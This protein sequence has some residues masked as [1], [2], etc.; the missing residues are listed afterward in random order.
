[1]DDSSQSPAGRVRRAG[2]TGGR[3]V[4]A[5]ALLVVGLVGG[6]PRANAWGD[7]GH[8]I[9][10]LV[11]GYLLEPAVRARVQALLAA[12]TS[13]LTRDTGIGSEATW[14]DHYRDS[15]RHTT[16][17]RY[18]GTRNWHFVDLELERAD[19][20]AAC[21]QHPGLP[22]GIAASM[23]PAEACII[24]KINEFRAEL[25]SPGT[26]PEE[27]LRALQFLLHL[28]GDLHQPLHACDDH[29]QGGNALQVVDPENRGGNLH[30]YWDSVFVA[31][32]GRDPSTV[33]AALLAGLDAE[34]RARLA[35]GDPEDWALESYALAHD[36]VYG[37]LGPAQPDGRY[38]LSAA[39]VEAATGVTREQ[40]L[41]AGIR[42]ANLLNAALR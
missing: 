16:R 10:A 30:H 7:E 5:L 38:A 41:R 15:D 28:V 22:P 6:L 24:D 25:A 33:A 35:G 13:G 29:D 42:L 23:G 17:Q 19:L 18:D 26:A 39:Y 40:L 8:E 27:R 1:M 11:A 36:Q 3:P 12:D 2:V 37:A 4:A 9:I 31:R 14:A 32:L 34:E 21:F 20:A